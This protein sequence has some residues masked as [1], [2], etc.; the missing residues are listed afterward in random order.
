MFNFGESM[1]SLS[2]AEQ[3]VYG[4]NQRL[5]RRK[6]KKLPLIGTTKNGQNSRFGHGDSWRGWTSSDNPRRIEWGGGRFCSSTMRRLT[7]AKKRS[8]SWR[9][10]EWR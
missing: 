8:A 10:V 5:F 1:V 3:V 2:K 4:M 9:R 6:R 7:L